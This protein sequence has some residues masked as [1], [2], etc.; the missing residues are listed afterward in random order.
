M[1]T[2]QVIVDDTDSGIQYTGS[3]SQTTGSI[4]GLGNFGPPFQSTSHGVNEDASLSYAFTGE[5]D[6]IATVF[7]RVKLA[8][9]QAPQSQ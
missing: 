3:W 6:R 5:L 9:T 2:P 8:S 7:A 4:D 1:A